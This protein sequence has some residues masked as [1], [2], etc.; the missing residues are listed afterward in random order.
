LGYAYT[1]PID[2]DADPPMAEQS[3]VSGCIEQLDLKFA[4]MNL[5]FDFYPVKS[6]I[7]CL[8][9]GTYIGNNKISAHGIADEPFVWNNQIINVVGGSFDTYLK[10]GNVFKPYAGIGLG[11]TIS[12]SRVSFRFDLGVIYQGGYTIKNHYNYKEYNGIIEL[13]ESSS[14]LPFSN[15]LLKWWPLLS[16]SISYRII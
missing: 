7:F 8:T 15:D 13:D 6:G 12:K 16:F 5:L 1:K 3:T 9:A 2:F 4:N 14:D 10:M 11:R